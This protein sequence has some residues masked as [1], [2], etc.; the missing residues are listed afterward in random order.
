VDEWVRSVNIQLGPDR[1]WYAHIAIDTSTFLRE[2]Y[3]TLGLHCNS[4]GK[5]RLTHVIAEDICGGHVPSRNS[6]IPV[7]IQ[8]RA[9]PF[10]G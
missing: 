8:A 4:R 10:I 5:M 3:T 7:I 9:S 1:A 2:E 6:S